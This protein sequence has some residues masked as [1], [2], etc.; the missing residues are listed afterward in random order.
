MRSD[1]VVAYAGTG[2]LIRLAPVNLPRLGEVAVDR[3]VLAFAAA[4]SVLA[5]LVFG[6]RPAW[7]AARVDVREALAEGG[8]RGTIGGGSARLRTGLAVAEI[9]LAV[10][11]AIGGGVL[12]RSFM[13]LSTVPLG[14]RTR[15]CSSSRPTCRQPRRCRESG[16][17]GGQARTV[18]AGVAL[19]AG[20][21]R[22]RG[23]LRTAD[24]H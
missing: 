3:G 24:E 11:L 10:V 7:H 9:G 14:Y 5:S 4:A 2:A 23:G 8:T 1:S 12:F 21:P 15:T 18:A 6:R 16:A 19:G 17:C 20:R 22:R 13:A